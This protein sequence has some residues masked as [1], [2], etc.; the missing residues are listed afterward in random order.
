MF[1]HGVP[2][3]RSNA[4]TNPYGDATHFGPTAKPRTTSS[5]ATTFIIGARTLSKRAGDPGESSLLVGGVGGLYASVEA[6]AAGAAVA[7]A[8]IA[9][10]TGQASSDTATATA[11]APASSGGFSSRLAPVQQSGGAAAA[12]EASGSLAA[13]ASATVAYVAAAA[14]PRRRSR[15]RHAPPYRVVCPSS[16]TTGIQWDAPPAAAIVT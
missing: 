4:R 1:T 12:G 5:T 16:R 10:A 11:A 6:H 15:A 9:A 8:V 13:A 2:W 14:P 3:G 7:S